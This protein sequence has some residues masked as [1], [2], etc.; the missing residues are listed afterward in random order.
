MPLMLMSSMPTMSGSLEED[1]PAQTQP[2]ATL[3]NVWAA[4]VAVSTVLECDV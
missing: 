2:T 1:S 3:V 4:V